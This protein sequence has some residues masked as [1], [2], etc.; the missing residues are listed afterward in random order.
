MFAVLRETLCLNS[1][2]HKYQLLDVVWLKLSSGMNRANVE[3]SCE[4]V[5][6]LS[7]TS[8]SFSRF[9]ATPPEN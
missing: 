5:Y 9:L 3:S 1:G 4:S 7:F 8:K 2:G 6:R